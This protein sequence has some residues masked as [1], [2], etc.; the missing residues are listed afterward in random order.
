M[1]NKYKN[2]NGELIKIINN[3]MNKFTLFDDDFYNGF[4]YSLNHFIKE[5]IDFTIISKN[6]LIDLIDNYEH[7]IDNEIIYSKEFKEGV[8]SGFKTIYDICYA[9]MNKDN[10]IVTNNNELLWVSI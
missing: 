2:N 6:D 7:I 9:N 1:V 3:A 4:V 10:N 5:N 8:K